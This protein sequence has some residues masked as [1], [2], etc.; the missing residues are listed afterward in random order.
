[1][2]T[3]LITGTNRGIGQELC[4]Q[5]HSKGDKV[6]AVC[7]QSN[8]ELENLGVRLETGVDI[9]SEKDVANLVNRLKGIKLDVLINNAGI[10]ERN[11]L[12]DLDFDSIRKQF[13]VNAIGTLRLTHALLPLMESG[14]KI[15]IITSRM[16]SIDDNTSGGTYGYRMSKVAVSMAGKSLSV[17][18]KPQGIAVAILHPGL[19]STRMTS[20][21]GISPA[22]AAENLLA[23]IDELNLENTGTFWHAK[24]EVLPW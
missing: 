16:G 12:D 23:R 10:V 1:M 6:I 19:I 4:K 7:R 15:A 24:G 9:T 18:L 21:T 22:E 8:Q 20:F 14:S 3:Y 2:A 11:S 5:V 17:D 13:E